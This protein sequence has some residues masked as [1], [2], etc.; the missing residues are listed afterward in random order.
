MIKTSVVLMALI[1]T[2]NIAGL[3]TS[4]VI[5]PDKEKFDLYEK[6]LNTGHLGMGNI[7]G[8]IALEAAYN[9]GDECLEELLEYLWDNYL[10]LETFFKNNLPKVKVMKPEATYLVWLD[11]RE[12]GMNDK[13][14]S[15]FI[16]R[17]AK[18]GLNNGARFGI[19]GNGWMRLNTGCPRSILAEGLER[20]GKAF[21]VL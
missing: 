2:F 18:V 1:K 15:T 20:L 13:E 4:V 3:A 16:V 9:Y 8:S 11:F 10:F 7:F 17:K 19:E 21:S 6:T 12:Y 5:I 14:L